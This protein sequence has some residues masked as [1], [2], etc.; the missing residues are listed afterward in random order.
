MFYAH[1]VLAKKGPLARIWLAAH[2]DKKLT[3]AHVF[4]TNI[5][6]SVDGILQPKV[7]MALR[8]SGHLLLGVVRIYSRKAKYLLAD[9]NEAFVKIKMA[10]RPGMVD[11]PEEHREAAVNAITLPEVFHDFD[12]TMPELNDVDIEAQFSLNQSR[13]EEITMREDYGNITLVSND[14]GFGDMGFDTDAPDLMRHTSSLEPSMEQSNLLFSDGPGLDGVGGLD[15]EREPIPSTSGTQSSHHAPMEVDAPIRDD[16]FG[17]NLDQNIMSGGLFEGGLFDDAPMDV[18]PPV[19]QGLQEQPVQSSRSARDSDDDDDMDHFGGPPSVGGHSSASSR[20][21]SALG[22]PPPETSLH[23]PPSV[24][25]QH[26]DMIEEPPRTSPPLEQTTLLQNEEESFALAPV[27]ASV[28]R[29]QSFLLG[30]TKTKRKRKLIVDEIKNISG[31]EMKNQL[32]DTTDIVT[33]LDLAPPT[34]RLMHWKETGGVEKLFALPARVIPARALSKNYQRHLILRCIGTEDFAMLGDA[35]SLALEQPREIE[36][37]PSLEPP[38]PAKRGRKRKVVEDVSK[39]PLHHSE[40]ETPVP[41]E[42]A[43][44][45]MLPPTPLA[46]PTPLHLS[47]MISSSHDETEQVVMPPPPTPPPLY[48]NIPSIPPPPSVAYPGPSQTPLGYPGTPGPPS[49]GYPPSVSQPPMMYSSTPAPPTSLVYPGTPAA[50]TPLSHMEEMPH[51]QPD[52]VRSLLQEQESLGALVR[53][54]TPASTEDL[55]GSMT[56]TAP[57]HTASF[58]QSEFESLQRIQQDLPLSTMENMGYNQSQLQMANMGYDENI[59]TQIPPGAMSERVQSPW[60]ADYDFPPSAGPVSCVHLFLLL[61]RS[62]GAVNPER[63]QRN[64]SIINKI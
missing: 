3:K 13:A 18:V 63:I 56:T 44:S 42:D 11:L 33:T 7:K 45:S 32:S 60:H 15:K 58:T 54:M 46:Q 52:Q 53:P 6:K 14:D 50:P 59:S 43:F 39:T 25:E 28:L 8:T 37:Q 30:L 62:N 1:F 9:C 31:E 47:H 34:K 49:V 38:T 23:A 61:Y 2:W 51:L 4:E 57:T 17:T 55:L 64:K 22:Q 40:P 10:F 16:G 24:P 29:G 20:P 48:P 27:D 12:T 19:D 5:E 36:E 35:D 21:P 41:S 26:L